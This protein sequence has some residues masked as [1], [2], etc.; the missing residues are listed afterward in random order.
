VRKGDRMMV[1][2]ECVDGGLRVVFCIRELS[3]AGLAGAMACFFLSF[4]GF[5]DPT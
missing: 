5:E 3:G 2:L 4:L 1:Y